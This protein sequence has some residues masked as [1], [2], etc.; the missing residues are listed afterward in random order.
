MLGTLEIR[1]EKAAERFLEKV[2]LPES[3]EDWESECWI[4]IGAK[5]GQ[6]R[7]YGKFRLGGKVVPAHRAAYLIFV[8]DVADGMVVG[9]LCNREECASPYHLIECSQSDNMLYSVICGRHNSCK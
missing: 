7:G 3:D 5:H 9:H 8:G 4:W 2:R 6:N 1:D